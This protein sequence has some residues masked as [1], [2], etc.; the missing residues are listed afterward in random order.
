[1]GVRTS[2]ARK[3]ALDSSEG[4]VGGGREGKVAYDRKI[5]TPSGCMWARAPAQLESPGTHRGNGMGIQKSHKLQ[6]YVQ[7]N[8]YGSNAT[9]CVQQCVL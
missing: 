2:R 8:E 9:L 4:K 7:Q 3:R 5:L 6:I 1:M